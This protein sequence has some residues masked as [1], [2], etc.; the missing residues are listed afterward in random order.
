MTSA[1]N[2][3]I[4]SMSNMLGSLKN[5]TDHV[6]ESANVLSDVATTSEKANTLMSETFERINNETLRQNELIISVSNNVTNLT[7]SAKHLKE[8]MLS[9]SSAMQ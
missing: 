6:L 3:L 9:E 5:E 1:T 7:E 2:E 4:K 8:Y